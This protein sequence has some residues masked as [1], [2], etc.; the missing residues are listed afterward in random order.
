MGIRVEQ[1]GGG[2][3]YYLTK[4][5]LAKESSYEFHLCFPLPFCGHIQL[6]Y[7]CPGEIAALCSVLL[8]GFTL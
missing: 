3:S 4:I 6:K 8:L 5:L 1:R 2:G 7:M